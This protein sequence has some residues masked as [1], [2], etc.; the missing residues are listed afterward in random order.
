M[1]VVAPDSPQFTLCCYLVFVLNARS[2]ERVSEVLKTSVK[3]FLLLT[4]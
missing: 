2:I 4:P 1:D 3:L